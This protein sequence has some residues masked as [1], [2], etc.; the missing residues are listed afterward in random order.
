MRSKWATTCATLFVAG[1]PDAR[2][3]FVAHAPGKWLADLFA[4]ARR[5]LAR[6]GVASVFGG[7][8]CTYSDPAQVLF[9]PPRSRDRADGGAHL[10]LDERDAMTCRRSSST[11]SRIAASH[12]PVRSPAPV[13]T[14]RP[15]TT[16][17]LDHYRD[18]RRRRAVGRGRRGARAE[19]ARVP[20]SDLISYAVGT[21]LGAV[22]LELLPQAFGMA[23]SLESLAA[24][25]LARLL[26]FFVLE[27][28]VLWRHCHQEQCEGAR[29]AARSRTITGAA[30]R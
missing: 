1:D 17:G 23:D 6:A 13:Y 20:G 19:R 14:D 8:L 10:A 28:L 29:P 12:M 4:L 26:L 9:V 15:M 18:A 3:A 22:F 5:R 24:I 16:L 30:A 25:I 21:L 27:K 2:S 7:G 11:E